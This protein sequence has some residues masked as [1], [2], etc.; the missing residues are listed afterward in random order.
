MGTTALSYSMIQVNDALVNKTKRSVP[1]HFPIVSRANKLLRI[2]E[3][4]CK[5]NITEYL[6]KYNKHWCVKKAT[7]GLENTQHFRT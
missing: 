1:L 5:K 2:I 6:L 7:L 4:G 3:K